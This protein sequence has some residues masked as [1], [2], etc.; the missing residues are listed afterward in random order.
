MPSST[1]VMLPTICQKIN[2]SKAKSIL[3]IGIGFGKYGFLAREYTD[4]CAR[5]YKSETWKVRIDG[6]E[7]F[8]E[9]ITPLHMLIYDNV[10][11]GSAKDMLAKVDNYDLIMFFDVIE[12]MNKADGLVVLNLIKQKSKQALVSTPMKMAKQGKL[13]GNEHERHVQQWTKKD[14]E[15]FGTVIEIK[16]GKKGRGIYLLEMK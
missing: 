15:A 10:Y 14:L 4:V 8:P 2:A 5:N 13:Y 16:Y 3:D 1:W 11:V 7:I 12:H 6:I 9:Y